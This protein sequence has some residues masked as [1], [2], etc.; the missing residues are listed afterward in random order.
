MTIAGKPALT[1]EERDW[2]RRQVDARRREKVAAS[3]AKVVLSTQRKMTRDE[4]LAVHR[5]FQDGASIDEIAEG[6][7]ERYGYMSKNHCSK[8][9]GRYFSGLPLTQAA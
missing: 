2:L 5:S 8:A 6:I 9:L 1:S 4:V 3:S 7:W